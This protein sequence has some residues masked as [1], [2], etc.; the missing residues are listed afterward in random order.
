MVS[1]VARSTRL[2]KPSRVTVYLRH[3]ASS[4][5]RHRADGAFGVN[6][7]ACRARSGPAVSGTCAYGPG[8][9]GHNVPALGPHGMVLNWLLPR[10]PPRIRLLGLARDFRFVL[11]R[12]IG[13]LPSRGTRREVRATTLG[14]GRAAKH[15][16]ASSYRVLSRIIFSI[17]TA[18]LAVNF[19]WR[20]PQRTATPVTRP[21]VPE[22]NT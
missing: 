15:V 20:V 19:R 16:V 6:A 7:R 13:Y 3:V 11:G 22:N 21:N 8:G 4:P 10:E 9:R 18:Y 2:E 1:R 14:R 12:I 5:R 17:L